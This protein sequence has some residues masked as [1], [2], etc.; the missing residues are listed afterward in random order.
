MIGE[1][2]IQLRQERGLDQTE[3][4]E[5]AGLPQPT[6]SRIENGQRRNPNAESMRRIASALNV[7]VDDLYPQP[8]E[9]AALVAA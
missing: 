7:K 3:L 2:I 5:R 6:V 9:V 4:A 8:T 1:R